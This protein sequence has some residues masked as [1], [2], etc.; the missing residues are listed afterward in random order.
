MVD[1]IVEVALVVVV[2]NEV[3]A[4]LVVEDRVGCDAVVVDDATV[5]VLPPP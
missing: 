1:G 3:V 5:V 4:V 2:G